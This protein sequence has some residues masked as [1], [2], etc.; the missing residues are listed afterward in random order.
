MNGIYS[1]RHIETVCSRGINFM[2]LLEGKPVPDHATIAR[3]NSLHLSD[4]HKK[5]DVYLVIRVQKAYLKLENQDLV[6]MMSYA[7]NLRC[8]K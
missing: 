4:E 5:I 1:S 7:K 3:F 2:Y 8:G 6:K